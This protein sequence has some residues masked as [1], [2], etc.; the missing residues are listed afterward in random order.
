MTTIRFANLP[1]DLA[2]VEQ[3]LHL[4]HA[5]DRHQP[6]GEH[7]YLEL[8][9][10]PKSELIGL[11]AS[12]GAAVTG[13][14]GLTPGSEDGWWILEL[15]VHPSW[16]RPEMYQELLSGAMEAAGAKG[17]KAVRLWAVEA[18][19]V[20]AALAAGFDPERELRLMRRPL[21]IDL[22]PAYPPGVIVDRFQRG[23]DEGPWLALNNAAFRGHPEN[24]NW[25]RSVLEYRMGQ[26]WFDPDDFITAR[27]Q[28]QMIGFCWVK[29][30]DAN[31][32]EIYV[33]AVS[34]EWQGKGL[35]RALTIDGLRLMMDKGA[36]EGI[37]YA[38]SLNENAM[39]L[40][41]SLGFEVDHAD[42]SLVRSLV[43]G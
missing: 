40:Y 25:S 30:E 32:G 6:I 15:V 21:P 9:A 8:A 37:L 24:G 26:A 38:D 4:A 39:R 36:T 13:Y 31:R 23:T 10:G 34:P 16:R 14:A 28:G 19:L 3:L 18:G 1:E 27:A 2:D 12:Q 22:Q 33:I 20:E 5:A 17:G 7:Q 35:G 41:E 29:R 11:I 43:A 42:W